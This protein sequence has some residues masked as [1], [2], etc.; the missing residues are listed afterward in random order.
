MCIRDRFIYGPTNGIYF[1][2]SDSTLLQVTNKAPTARGVRLYLKAMRQGNPML[3]ARLGSPTGPII[4]QQAVDV[5]DMSLSGGDIIDMD[6]GETVI[7]LVM[8]PFIPDL[9]FNPSMFA[10]HATF[11]DGTTTYAFHSSDF[12]TYTLSLIHI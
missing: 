5:F 7:R 6:T 11:A 12:T 3:Q 1:T 10:H 4:A 2:S 9:D 8:T